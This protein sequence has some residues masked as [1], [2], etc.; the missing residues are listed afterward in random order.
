MSSSL[1]TDKD[2]DRWNLQLEHNPI[3][4]KAKASRIITDGVWGMQLDLKVSL[5]L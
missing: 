1:L 2:R 3:C 4:H 5:L